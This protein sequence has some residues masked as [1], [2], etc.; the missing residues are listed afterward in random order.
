MKI[1]SAVMSE[2][3]PTSADLCLKWQLTN[4]QAVVPKNGY[5][6]DLQV[7]PQYRQRGK[8]HIELVVSD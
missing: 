8:Q 6:S 4:S 2:L 7:S 5:T 1:D 3:M